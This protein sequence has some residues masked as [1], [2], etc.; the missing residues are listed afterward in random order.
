[1][2]ENQPNTGK[3]A[4]M[5]GAIIGGI[6]IV[7][8]L[9]LY[10]A[11]L[12]YQIDLKRLLINVVIGLIF[13]VV[14]SIIAMKAFKKENGGYMSIGQGLKVGV[15]MALVSGIISI[16]FGFVLSKVI[17][18]DMQ[19]KAIEYGTEVMRDYGMTEAQIDEQ[20]EQQ[21]N[22]NLFWQVA[23]GL[24]FSLVFGFIGAIIPAVV[25]KRNENID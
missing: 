3:Y 6:G 19:Q 4:L 22:P 5:Y 12:H 7:F 20:L 10:S 18:P 21:K 23:Q 16:L 17:D 8:S 14:G 13:I 15:G 1:M 25:L 24:I 2:E 9:M 11:D